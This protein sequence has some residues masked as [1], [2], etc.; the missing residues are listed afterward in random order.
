M[1]KKLSNLSLILDIL[2]KPSLRWSIFIILTILIVTFAPFKTT[3]PAKAAVDMCQHAIIKNEDDEPIIYT[4]SQQIH[5]KSK[6]DY[7]GT[8]KTIIV[9]ASQPYHGFWPSKEIKDPATEW[10]EASFSRSCT[11]AFSLGNHQIIVKL[12]VGK[13]EADYCTV[14]YNVVEKEEPT[15][16]PDTR[17]HPPYCTITIDSNIDHTN[18]QKFTPNVD[19]F[20]RV[21]AENAPHSPH[22]VVVRPA[23]CERNE[24]DVFIPP[25]SGNDTFLK[26]N[27]GTFEVIL[28]G[29]FP[30]YGWKD[31]PCT[32]GF[33][34]KKEGGEAIP[35]PTLPIPTSTPFPTPTD[36]P[37]C[38]IC[39]SS[40][41]D[42]LN[43]RT[44][45]ICRPTPTPTSSIPMPDIKD[46]CKT[47]SSLGFD[48]CINCVKGQGKYNGSPGIWTAIGCLPTNYSKLI[49][50]K[51]FPIGLG[52]AGGIAFLY[53]I[54]GC[55]LI[56]TS[57]GNAEKVQQGKQIIVSALS[58]LLFIIFSVFILK[59]IGV[60][61][62]QLPEF[63]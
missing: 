13:T 25:D 35:T 19:I 32:S 50:E 56:L 59:V 53:F 51:I 1:L 24:V 15:P 6:V 18:G 46:L 16:T 58:G 33:T 7:A 3:M 28:Q 41:C 47:V 5:F 44:C 21:K 39:N 57:M 23:G 34:I 10:L 55:F 61:I 63:K 31:T 62:L 36:H 54:Y 2:S 12:V 8:Y 20:F 22:R 60:D 40:M 49:S 38:V 42:D 27:L 17:Y 45:R 4:N 14:P 43:C 9:G 26:C 29:N 30:Q 48:D 52:L 37:G 11:G